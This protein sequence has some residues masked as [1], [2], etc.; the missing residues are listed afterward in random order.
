MRM[1]NK[2]STI[3][4]SVQQQA[5]EWLVELQSTAAN[6]ETHARWQAWC[7][8]HPDHFSAWQRIE[9]FGERLHGLSSPL[10]HAALTLPKSDARRRAVKT[11]AAALFVGG[12]AWVA[13]CELPWEKWTADRRTS[14]GE[15]TTIVLED[16]TRL[17]LNARTAIDIDYSDAERRIRLIEGEIHIVT[18]PDS[19]AESRQGRPFIVETIHGTLRALGTQ[20]LVRQ[21]HEEQGT[22]RIAVYEGA[23]EIRPNGLDERLVIHAGQ[24][25]RFGH[26]HWDDP[27]HADE[28]VAAWTE[29]MLVVRDMPLRTFLQELEPHRRG[30]LTCDDRVAILKVTGTYPL[31]NTDH[32]LDMLRT[33]L[34]VDVRFV[35]RYWVKVES[36]AA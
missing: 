4:S 2:S 23:V 8:A 13:K 16:G 31:A 32:I 33:T 27:D 36:P 9:A 18:A 29:G 10:A 25:T 21:R 3:P 19:M 30:Y 20:F 5:A 28:N 34:P 14:A 12:G 24:Q 6:T 7:N 26:D 11:L 1:K 17:K 35:T 15:R 22:S